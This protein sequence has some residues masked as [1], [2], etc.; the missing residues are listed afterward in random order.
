VPDETIII[1]G[2]LPPDVPPD[3]PPAP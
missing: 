2:E 1:E 3:P